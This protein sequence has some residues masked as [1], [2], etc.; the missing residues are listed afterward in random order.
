VGVGRELYGKLSELPTRYLFQESNPLQTISHI[1][2]LRVTEI[3][4]SL[5]H[6]QCIT[7]FGVFSGVIESFNRLER[8]RAGMRLQVGGGALLMLLLHRGDIEKS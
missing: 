7:P 6:L 4:E 1:L 8:D 5:L 3:T 2:L